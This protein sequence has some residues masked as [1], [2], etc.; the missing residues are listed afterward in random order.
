[1]LVIPYP[2]G[3]V[4]EYIGGGTCWVRA[5]AWSL[6]AV[7]ALNIRLSLAWYLSILAATMEGIK[8]PA[9]LRPAPS[10]LWSTRQRETSPETQV[11]NLIMHMSRIINVT[12]LPQ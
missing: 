2:E 5:W 3:G 9:K 7:S 11:L 8:A 4:G 12:N 6:S 1:M 10:R